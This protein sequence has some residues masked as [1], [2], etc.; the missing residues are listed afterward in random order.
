MDE[1]ER[2]LRADAAE[3]SV[4]VSEPLG[5]RIDAALAAA[6]R[7]EEPPRVRQRRFGWM[8][9]LSGAAA[10]MVA[11][12]LLNLRAERAPAPPN[13][14][15]QTRTVPVVVE[16]TQS[17]FVLDTRSAVLTDP[18]EEEL[19]HLKADFERARDEVAGDLRGSF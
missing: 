7:V 4:E 19:E 9:A 1:L 18:L 17:P 6:V 15:A 3:L 5:K 14:D 12:L 8:S 11:I 10:A 2:R 13:P 16:Q